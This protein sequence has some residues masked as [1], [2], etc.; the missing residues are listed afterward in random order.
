[1]AADDQQGWRTDTSS[2]RHCSSMSIAQR[3]VFGPVGAVIKFRDEAEAV[4]IAND[5]PFGLNSAIFTADVGRA[6]RLA[7]EI[8]S[9]T[10]NINSS[11]GGH[12]EAPFG[13]YKQ[14]G[15]GREGGS[16]GV[17]EFLQTKFVKW[18]AGQA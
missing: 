8:E 13:G 18:Q 6:F 12:P 9:G 16:H 11:F 10:V 1:M 17:S 14:S 7:R 5:S 2:T 4:R 15:L 3:E